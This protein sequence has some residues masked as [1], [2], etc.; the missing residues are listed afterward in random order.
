MTQPNFTTDRLKLRL[1]QDSD[2]H[3][4]ALLHS[5]EEVNKYIDRKPRSIEEVK[6]FITKINK[7][8]EEGQSFYWAICLKEKPELI[9]TVCL[10]GFSEDKTS[11]ELG[12]E[13][14]PELHGQGFM[15]E[16]LDP[17]INFSLKVLKLK[18]LD[19]YT[20]RDNKSSSLLLERKYF[21]LSEM[22][23]T[24]ENYL[25]YSLNPG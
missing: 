18:R 22:K 6:A 9:G 2:Y 5:N 15:S 12:Y 19:A 23:A 24:E 13:L 1:L 16:A 11:A 21:K 3:A 7:G 17:I 8:I 4:L 20:H 25:I 14:N 10:W